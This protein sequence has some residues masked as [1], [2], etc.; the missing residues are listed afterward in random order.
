MSTNATATAIAGNAA[1]NTTVNNLAKRGTVNAIAPT[2]SFASSYGLWIGIGVA[3]LVLAAIAIGVALY[4]SSTNTSWWSDR[5]GSSNEAREALF[6]TQGADTDKGLVP[7][8]APSELNRA[9]AR[10]EALRPE[11]WCFVGEDFEGRWCVKVPAR[12]ACDANRVFGSQDECELVRANALP[13][14]AVN[15]SRTSMT[16]LSSRPLGSR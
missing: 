14:G 2:A 6:R 16:P 10:K 12:S 8:V 11:S 4:K 1:V 13:S 3:L 9:A 5:I 15:D 7:P